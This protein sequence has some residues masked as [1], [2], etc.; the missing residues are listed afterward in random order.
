MS[1]TPLFSDYDTIRMMKKLSNQS[2]DK[3]IEIIE[4]YI[5]Q[6]TADLEPGLAINLLKK[7]LDMVYE[8]PN[9]SSKGQMLRDG[10]P[11]DEIVLFD[12]RMEDKV[13]D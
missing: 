2:N 6:L 13:F 1:S 10:Y 7:R 12:K 8:I 4:E 9:T 11:E 5:N 3:L